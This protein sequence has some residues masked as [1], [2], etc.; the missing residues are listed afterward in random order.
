MTFSKILI[1]NRGEIAMRIIRAAR[2]LGIP[3]VAVHSTVDR[4]SPHVRMA[5]EAFCIGPASSAESYLNIPTLLSVCEVTGADA[6]H[7][8]Y[9]FL[10]ENA[11][12]AE[13]CEVSGITWIGPPPSAINAMGDKIR[14]RALMLE[15]GVPIL[16]GTPGA[17]NDVEEAK[18]LATEIGFPM[19]L[20]AAA[21]GG[22]RGMKV[23]ECVE[24]LEQSWLT[25]SA[26]A[27]A[28]FGSGAVYMERYL[29]RP[30]HV[31]FQIVLDQYG[32][33]VHLFE[34][35]CSVQR[36]HQ[37]LL[38]EAPCVALDAETR[39]RVGALCVEA[40]QKIG[41]VGVGTFEFLYDT[42]GSMFFMEM[43][44]RIQVE[45]PVTEA[46]TGIDLVRLQI[47]IARGAHLPFTQDE[48]PGP[49]GHAME[50]RI[51]AE[52][53]DKFLPS[54]GTITAYEPAGGPGVRIDGLAHAGYTVLPHY[55]SMV[56]KLIIHGANR[57]EC[58]QRARRALHEYR[59]EGIA[60]T[61]PFHQRVLE[62]ESFVRGEYDT[63]LVTTM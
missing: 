2:D 39:K 18:R 53:P 47:D 57:E 56:A 5:D 38:E 16:P 51:N 61:I 49:F 13:L 28:A 4:E 36:R 31:E 23:V 27:A 48:V 44:T 1:A 26:E 19:I 35:E 11:Q 45:H 15:A 46:I 9:G 43:N 33:G 52:T 60:T 32:A 20:K 22:G 34:R 62:N 17:I 10:S 41:Y 50:F 6:V 12:F 29:R 3:T 24:D 40:S 8:G 14:A 59:I 25:C 7:P 21:G 55:D 37:K 54:P 58:M 30:R 63:H 42:D